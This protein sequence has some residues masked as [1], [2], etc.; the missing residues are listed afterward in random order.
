MKKAIN[1]DPT[2]L[3]QKARTATPQDLT[4]A[5]DLRDTLLAHQDN[6]VG[7]AANMIGEDVAI[8]AVLMGPLPVIMINP[9]ITQK[10]GRY[11]TQEGC[12]SLT[13]KRPCQRYRQITVSYQDQNFERHTIPLQGLVAETVQHEV[14]HLSGILI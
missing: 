2:R 5:N 6:C 14:D 12:L 4:V 11:Q 7:M 1:H 10:S 9:K 3:K 13:G 8:I